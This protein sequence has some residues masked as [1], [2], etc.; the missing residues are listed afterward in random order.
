M[1]Y[2]SEAMK[3]LKEGPSYWNNEAA[4][5]A[6]YFVETGALAYFGLTI[7]DGNPGSLMPIAL[8][9][10]VRGAQFGRK[11]LQREHNRQIDDVANYHLDELKRDLTD[12]NS[13]E[14][15]LEPLQ[16]VRMADENNGRE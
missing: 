11:D 5:I 9:S 16:A 12:V 1:N 13:R 4:R 8:Q 14:T 3:I 7:T 6:H 2:L 15:R 10:F